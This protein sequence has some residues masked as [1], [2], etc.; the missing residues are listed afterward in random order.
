MRGISRGGTVN[1]NGSCNVGQ[2]DMARQ[3]ALPE[4]PF[5]PGRLLPFRAVRAP[6]PGSSGDTLATKKEMSDFLASVERRSFKQ[7]VFATRDE[8]S[9]LDIVQDAMMRL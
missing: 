4:G 8:D 9:A 1:H 7:A 3:P 5:A 6:L 2:A